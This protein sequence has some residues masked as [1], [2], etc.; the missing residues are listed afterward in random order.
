MRSPS[1]SVPLSGSTGPPRLAPSGASR[2]GSW[3]KFAG[4]PPPGPLRGVATYEDLY[5]LTLRA[6]GERRWPAPGPLTQHLGEDFE[7]LRRAEAA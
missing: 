4:S 7:T 1:G 2:V 6:L 3:R 5:R